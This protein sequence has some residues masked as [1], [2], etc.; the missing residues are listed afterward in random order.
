M[1]FVFVESNNEALK[2]VSYGESSLY[3]DNLPTISYFIEKDL[4]TKFRN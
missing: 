2:L 1:N 3:I 4:L